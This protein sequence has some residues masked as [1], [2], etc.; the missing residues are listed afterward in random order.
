M[1]ESLGQ[2]AR[3]CFSTLLIAK[4]EAMKRGEEQSP[5]CD[6]PP[7]D[8]VPKPWVPKP[9]G[10]VAVSACVAGPRCERPPPPD[11]WPLRGA[12][13]LAPVTVT[14]QSL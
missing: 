7:K 14:H 4:Q 10:C 5:T 13:P 9:P 11:T 3:A 6:M 2:S 8:C 1:Q 12:R